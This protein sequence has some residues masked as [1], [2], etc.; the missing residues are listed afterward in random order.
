MRSAAPAVDQQ[1]RRTVPAD[2]RVQAH[3]AGVYV[4]ARERVGEVRREVRRAETEPGPSA[5][6]RLEEGLIRTSF[7][8]S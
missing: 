8:K 4:V 2:D 6:A 5:T 7:Q 3:V 1:Q